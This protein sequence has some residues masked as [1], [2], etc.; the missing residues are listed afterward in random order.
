MRTDIFSGVRGKLGVLLVATTIS[1]STVSCSETLEIPMPEATTSFS[2]DVGMILNGVTLPTVTGLEGTQEIDVDVAQGFN[3]ELTALEPKLED[4]RGS[5]DKIEIKRISY[6]VKTNTLNQDLG[7]IGI[8]FGELDKTEPGEGVAKYGETGRIVAGVT[9]D[10]WID[11]EEAAAPDGTDAVS[12]YLTEFD[13][14]NIMAIKK[15]YYNP[16]VEP[17]G[18]IEMDIQLELSFHVNVS[19]ALNSIID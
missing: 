8:Y 14:S 15:M 19:D 18:E 2:L 1:L 4:Y 6:R 9:S 5:V 13:F 10:D 16:A 17:A 12:E 11:V 3:M 7:P